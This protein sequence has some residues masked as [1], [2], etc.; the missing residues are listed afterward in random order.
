MVRQ[1]EC[2]VAMTRAIVEMLR[3]IKDSLHGSK[4][5][6]SPLDPLKLKYWVPA[7]FLPSTRVVFKSRTI[8]YTQLSSLLP[9][10]YF[11]V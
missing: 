4:K 9:I 10:I 11:V 5:K 2:D 3:P 7:N 8:L 1:E 6:G